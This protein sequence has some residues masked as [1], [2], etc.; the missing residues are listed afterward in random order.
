MVASTG[1]DA[2]DATQELSTHEV[3]FVEDAARCW[4]GL[5]SAG[6]D[7]LFRR[8][9]THHASAIIEINHAAGIGGHH[10][11][12]QGQTRDVAGAILDAMFPDIAATTR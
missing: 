8:D 7:V 3:Q 10:F 9:D 1:A 11:P 12:R 4:P 6:I 5:R 2:V